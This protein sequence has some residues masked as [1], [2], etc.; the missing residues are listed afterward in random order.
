[1]VITYAGG[2]CF[3]L[4]AGDVTLALNPPSA[5]SQVKVSKFGADVILV[6][7]HHEDWN[8]VET[9][10][11]ASREPFVINGPGAYEVGDVV[12][13]GYA[14]EGAQVGETSEFGNTA[15][16]IEFDGMSI[17]VLGAL[18]SP[19]LSSDMRGDLNNVDIVFVPIG[20]ATLDPKGAHDLVVSL[21]TKLVIPYG[22]GK[23][24]ADEVKAF[25]KGEGSDVK[26]VEKLTL[27]AK[28]VALMSG[29]I[30]LLK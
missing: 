8:G 19:K 20:G 21:E 23:N 12:V 7:S 16:F 9:A 10:T 22:V 1:M 17:L 2:N 11:H 18:S 13:T 15:Y 5:R 3:K 14:T 30:A 24:G 27:R 4:S 25:V 26:A 28:E 6:S 29:D